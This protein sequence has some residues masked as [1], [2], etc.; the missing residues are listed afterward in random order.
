MRPLFFISARF[1]RNPTPRSTAHGGRTWKKIRF[2]SPTFLVLVPRSRDGCNQRHGKSPLFRRMRFLLARGRDACTVG[3]VRHDRATY[4]RC[5]DM[6]WR[7]IVSFSFDIFLSLE[8]R[9]IDIWYSSSNEKCGARKTR[10]GKKCTPRY[11]M[12]IFR[13]FLFLLM[14]MRSEGNDCRSSSSQIVI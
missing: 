10:R 6:R 11:G 3:F 14:G 7:F 2:V 1:P 12:R 8:K 5:Y 4:I 9:G 13:L